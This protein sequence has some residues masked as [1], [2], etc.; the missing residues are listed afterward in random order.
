MSR[1]ETRRVAVGD[2]VT[3]YREGNNVGTVVAL[4]RP[5]WA[6]F[7]RV[8]WVDWGRGALPVAHA[9]GV[10]LVNVESVARTAAPGK[11]TDG[12]A[13]CGQDAVDAR[14]VR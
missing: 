10:E 7:G 8:W 3:H 11:A 5:W 1:S 9:F 6:F 2:R 4:R 12:I 13:L 14:V